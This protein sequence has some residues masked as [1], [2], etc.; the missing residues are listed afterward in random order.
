MNITSATVKVIQES[1]NRHYKHNLKVDGDAGKN[2]MAALLQVSVIPTEWNK[3][4][5]LVGYIQHICALENIDA[6]PVD[7]YWGPQTDYG[8][9][10]LKVALTTGKKPDPWR[11]DEGVGATPQ[12]NSWPIQTQDELERY[13]G[14]VGTNQTSVVVPYPLKIAWQTD[15]I[16]T[17]V[18]CHKKVANSLVEILEDVKDHYGSDGIEQLKLNY[19]GGMLN[20]RKMRGGSKWSTHAWGIAADFYPQGNQLRWNHKEAAFAR[21]EYAYWLDAWEKRGAISLGRAR[22]YDWMHTQFCRVK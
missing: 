4:R 7:G 20:V 15:R 12:P 1:L 2:T 3:E 8:F 5:K 16:I 19:F 21:P 17:K 14:P 22:D 11:D 13:Y 18:T 10:Q 9:E 6:G